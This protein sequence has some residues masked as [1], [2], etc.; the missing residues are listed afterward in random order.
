[1]YSKS[2]GW[3]RTGTA[4]GT[5]TLLELVNRTEKREGKGG[6][7]AADSEEVIVLWI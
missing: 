7:T 2:S 3:T 4:C 6:S 1:M 5:H